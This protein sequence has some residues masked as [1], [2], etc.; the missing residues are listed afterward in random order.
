MPRLDVRVLLYKPIIFGHMIKE[1]ICDMVIIVN[2]VKV[3]AMIKLCCQK[4]LLINNQSSYN[5]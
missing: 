2:F 1:M 4:L 5:L 3:I